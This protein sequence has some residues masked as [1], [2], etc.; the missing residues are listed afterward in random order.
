MYILR[1]NV[2]RDRAAGQDGFITSRS[3]F[4]AGFLWALTNFIRRNR[5]LFLFFKSLR[6]IKQYGIKKAAGEIVTG[7][8]GQEISLETYLFL[9]K[10]EKTFQTIMVFPKKFKISIIVDLCNTPEQSLKEM[11]ESVIEQTYGNWELYLADGSDKEHMNVKNICKI[12]AEKDNRIKYRKLNKNLGISGRLNQAI[13]MTTGEYIGILDQGD[14]L[15][16]SV[17]YEVMRVIC[18]E[19]ADFIYT[20]EAVFTNNHYISLVRHKPCYAVDTL[21]SYN[22][23]GHFVVFDKKLTEKA[24]V[25]RSEFDGSQ[26]YDLIFRYTDAATRVRHISKLLY[27]TRNG[28]KFTASDITKRMEATSAAERTISEYL[29]KHGKP[30]RVERKI[31]LQGYYRVIYELTEKPVISIIIPNKNNTTLLRD[32]IS[33]ILEKS[34]YENYEIIIVENNSLEETLFAFYEELK[35]YPNVHVV[36]W[37]GMGFNYSEICNFGVQ[38]SH[39]RHLVFMNNDVQIIS[40]DWIEE[41]LMYS[42]RRDVGAVGAKLYYLNGSIQH[43]GMILG[44]GGVAGH[45]YHGAPHNTVGYMGKLQIVQNMS[46]VTAACMMV[47]RDVFDEAGH[48]APEFPASFNDVDLC[49]KIRKAGYLVVWTPYAE[50]YHLESKSRGYNTTKE[51]K[52]KL[53]QETALFKLRWEKE[54]AEGDPYYNRNF[55]L[56][57]T[58][59]RL[60]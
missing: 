11:I 46:A 17:F 56:D 10:F 53:I 41:M 3:S 32:C 19:G 26:D 16:P 44:L 1:L 31:G 9:T 54:L 39:G 29:T 24:G 25:F 21:C 33:S 51:R 23:I 18:G 7:I 4:F 8:R 34:T 43:A 50:A 15:H 2:V 14:V 5:G 59:Y 48:F 38:H 37:K 35:L 22:Y 55:S 58:D 40:P 12:Y 27:F 57:K 36:Y 47:R 52:R 28:Y 49:L 45:V 6:F 60:V 13:E 30:A 42:Q 20:D